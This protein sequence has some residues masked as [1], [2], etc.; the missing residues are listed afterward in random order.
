MSV[1]SSPARSALALD[2]DALGRARH[3]PRRD[4]ELPASRRQHVVHAGTGA[5][6]SGQVEKS[7]SVARRRD[8]LGPK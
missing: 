6:V 2:T 4:G 8:G 1:R 3:V 5:N 7:G